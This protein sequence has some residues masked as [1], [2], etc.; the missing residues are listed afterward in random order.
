VSKGVNMMSSNP[1][2]TIPVWNPSC[3]RAN[4]HPL[5][6]RQA[7]VCTVLK[8]HCTNYSIVKNS[9]P[10][11][12]LKCMGKLVEK[13]MAWLLYSK[14][15]QHNLLPINQYGGRMASSMLDAGLML[16]HNIQVVY[17]AELWTGLLLF[18][19][20]GYF[21]NINKEQLVQVV[22]DLGFTLEIVS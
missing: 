8:P 21:N 15:I 10:V 20:Q 12:L 17:A 19:I 11:S 13:L 3:I 9:R 2:H 18:N 16:T 7:I 14:I 6:W 22:A 1:T 5:I 4:H